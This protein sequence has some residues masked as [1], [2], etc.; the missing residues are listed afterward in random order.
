MICP[1]CGAGRIVVSA[2]FP[3]LTTAEGITAGLEP[4][5]LLDSS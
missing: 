5:L 2:E 4:G 3:A 1:R